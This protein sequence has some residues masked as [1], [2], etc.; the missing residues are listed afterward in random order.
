[1]ENLITG[2]LVWK[3]T[4]KKWTGSP[5]NRFISITASIYFK[6]NLQIFRLEK[7]RAWMREKKLSYFWDFFIY[8]L[9]LFFLC[10]CSDRVA[11]VLDWIGLSEEKCGFL[12]MM[13]IFANF[14]CIV[15]WISIKI[16]LRLIWTG[17]NIRTDYNFL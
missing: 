17:S 2:T 12:E 13:Q 16:K 10:L 4:N 1:M 8:F 15:F 7:I 6:E 3:F 14:Y 11:G 9:M 5:I